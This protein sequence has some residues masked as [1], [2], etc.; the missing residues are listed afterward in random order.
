MHK[1]LSV[2]GTTGASSHLKKS[3]SPFVES[4]SHLEAVPGQVLRLIH[5]VVCSTVFC[6]CET[7]YALWCGIIGSVGVS[8]C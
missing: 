6:G 2:V 1:T 5:H 4:S 8:F 7:G 3:S